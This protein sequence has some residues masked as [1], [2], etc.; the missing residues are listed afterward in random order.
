MSYKNRISNNYIYLCRETNRLFAPNDVSAVI[1]DFHGSVINRIKILF[2][3]IF[4]V[5]RNII[6]YKLIVI[7]NKFVYIIGLDGIKKELR[8]DSYYSFEFDK[9]I[10]NGGI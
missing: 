8:K 7:K 1:T 9:N 2:N 4:F 5:F 3:R 6:E 10:N